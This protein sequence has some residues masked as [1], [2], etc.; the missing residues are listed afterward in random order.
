MEVLLMKVCLINGS[1]HE[2]EC[3]YTALMEVGNT[4]KADGI[5][6]DVYWLGTAPIAGC[7]GCGYCDK[8]D[9]CVTDGDPVNAFVPRVDDYDG[10]VFGSPVHFAGISGSMKSFMDR[11]FYVVQ[12]DKLRLKAAGVVLSARRAGTTAA[13]DQLIKYP[14]ISEM[15]LISSSYWNMV[16]GFTADEVRQDKE[17]MRTMRVLGHNM[18]WYLKARDAAIKAGLPA[19]QTE[20]PAWTHFIR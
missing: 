20:E 15:A 16:H 12:R 18:A 6:F 5:D 9:R 3:T 11:F 2:K 13:F 7:K 19:P 14:T 1:P 8:V 17:G 4:L 10:F